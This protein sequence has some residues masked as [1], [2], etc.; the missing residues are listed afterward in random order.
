MNTFTQ[1]QVNKM[2]MNKVLYWYS[3]GVITQNQYD[4]F[5]DLWY[6][7]PRINNMTF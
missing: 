3:Q 4:L 1:K 7:I 2:S 6:E 5:S